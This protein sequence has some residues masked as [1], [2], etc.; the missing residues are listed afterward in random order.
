MPIVPSR[1]PISAVVWRAT[2]I[3]VRSMAYTVFFAVEQRLRSRLEIAQKDSVWPSG[4]AEGDGRGDGHDLPVIAF[5]QLPSALMHHPVM[6]ATEQDQVVELGRT[7]LDPV[8]QV[9]SVAPRGRALAPWPAAVAVANF[10]RPPQGRRDDGLG[11]PHIHDERLLAEQ[12]AGHAA[13]AGHALDRDRGDG[14]RELHL[15]GTGQALQG[16]DRGRDLDVGRPAGRGQ[17]DQGVG[18]ALGQETVVGS[19]AQ[20]R[21]GDPSRLRARGS[22]AV[23]TA[24][25]P[26]GSRTP[27]IRRWPDSA[28]LRE[29]WWLNCCSFCSSAYFLA[30]T[31]CR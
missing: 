5:D 3:A 29:R 9:M 4:Q 14:K 6:P 26:T 31:E 15:R 18:V 23:R 19:P 1:T 8:D 12:D 7:A 22:R 25:P 10:Q 24:A 17:L 2:A 16:L 27:L 21:R 20:P 28:V 11:S 13:V 30:S